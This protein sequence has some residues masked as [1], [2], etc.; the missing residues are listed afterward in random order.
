MICT[1]CC[2][3][4]HLDTIYH[5]KHLHFLEL[6]LVKSGCPLMV[7]TD[8]T[9]LRS[10]EKALHRVLSRVVLQTGFGCLHGLSEGVSQRGS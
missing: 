6:L 3:L 9:G 2:Q 1:I 4:E 7:K 5:V 8:D 10:V